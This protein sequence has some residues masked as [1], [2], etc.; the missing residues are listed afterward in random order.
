MT[1]RAASDS[2]RDRIIAAAKAEFSRYGIAG[3]RIARI[4]KEA[5]TSTERV[6]AYFSGGKE[7]LYRFVSAQ[8]LAVIAE[9]TRMDPTDLPGFAGRLHD[10]YTAHPD[11]YRLV[12]WGRLELGD[13]ERPADH[14]MRQSASYKL[15]QTRK[16]QEAG[17]LDP[18]WDPMDILVIVS[19]IA[20][21]WASQPDLP[22]LAGVDRDTF[23]AARRAAIVTAVERL[24]PAVAAPKLDGTT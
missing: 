7:E 22:I 2:T 10:Y 15:E 14:P 24:F 1:P 3:A 23:L 11:R 8:E 9:A 20:T 12:V 19:Q 6:Y 13:A 18:A 21:G 4:A 16:A 17:Y 5:K